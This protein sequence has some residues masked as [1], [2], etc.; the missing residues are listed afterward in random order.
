MLISGRYANLQGKTW[1]LTKYLLD[2][3]PDEFLCRLASS[4]EAS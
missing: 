3:M 2:L 4:E 1:F